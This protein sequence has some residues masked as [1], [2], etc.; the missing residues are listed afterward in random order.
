MTYLPDCGDGID[1]PDCRHCS[2]T[3]KVEC[4]YCRDGLRGYGNLAETCAECE[5]TC[6][7]ACDRCGGTGTMSLDDE[8]ERAGDAGCHARLEEGA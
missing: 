8:R 6:R 4:S 7:I 1:A 5:G 2:G 3:G